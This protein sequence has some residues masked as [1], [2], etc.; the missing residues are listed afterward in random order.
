[1]DGTTV[2]GGALTIGSFGAIDVEYGSN[3]PSHGATFDGVTVNNNN[4]GTFEVG[5]TSAS[6]TVIALFEDGATVNNGTL[7]VGSAGALEVETAAGA[8]LNDVQVTNHNSIE[9]TSGSV[10]TLDGGTS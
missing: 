1:Y 2:N 7:T 9:V 3:G 4:G 6:G 8:T 10:L 5:E